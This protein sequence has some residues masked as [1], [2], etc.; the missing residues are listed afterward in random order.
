M[1]T[2]VSLAETQ[3]LMQSLPVLPG[4]TP[5]SGLTVVPPQALPNPPPPRYHLHGQ[6]QMS[7]ALKAI[8]EVKIVEHHR[9]GDPPPHTR[10]Q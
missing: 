1:A 10:Q 8:D 4:H 2:N 3:S 5:L 7:E 9:Y 6:A